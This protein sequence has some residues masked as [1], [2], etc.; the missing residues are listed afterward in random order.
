[1]IAHS[2]GAAFII[3]VR[4]LADALFSLEAVDG[5]EFE[6][7]GGPYHSRIHD[8]KSFATQLSPADK[9]LDI[10]PATVIPVF[11]TATF[12]SSVAN[13][14]AISAFLVI[15]DPTYGHMA[16]YQTSSLV[17]NTPLTSVSTVNLTVLLA[18]IAQEQ[19]L[20]VRG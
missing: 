19:R 10:T 20:S 7:S 14:H 8:R 13:G 16:L 1:M 6:I 12:R 18:S 9:S 2:S 5:G 11:P 17:D 3:S 4:W 15:H